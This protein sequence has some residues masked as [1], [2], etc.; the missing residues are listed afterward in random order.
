[1]GRP[2]HLAT[3]YDKPFRLIVFLLPSSLVTVSLLYHAS[4][5]MLTVR[6]PFW[7]LQAPNL[8]WRRHFLRA[9]LGAV[10]LRTQI[11]LCKLILEAVDE[12]QSRFLV[13]KFLICHFP[14]RSIHLFLRRPS[15]TESFY[16]T[17]KSAL[18]GISLGRDPIRTE[19]GACLSPASGS[20]M[21][22]SNHEAWQSVMDT[23]ALLY[24]A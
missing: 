10:A 5:S 1:M 8:L 18:D 21:I 23:Q 20:P 6:V 22:K 2:S 17:Q 9:F 16:I 15:I 13:R 4:R 3:K 7:I 19:T 14:F 11:R 24:V 12:Q